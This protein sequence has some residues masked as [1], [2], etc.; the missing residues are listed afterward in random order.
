MTKE[1]TNSYWRVTV[2]H[3]VHHVPTSDKFAFFAAGPDLCKR[4]ALRGLVRV[5]N[6][7]KARLVKVEKSVGG[8]IR[9]LEARG[10]T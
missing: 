8:Y 3:E 7:R 4:T 6:L 2:S 9:N 10:S 5:H 1:N